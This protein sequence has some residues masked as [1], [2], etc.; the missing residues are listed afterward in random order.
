M[1]VHQERW[2]ERAACAGQAHSGYSPWD[3]M[4]DALPG[5]GY[6]PAGITAMART[7]CARCP[8]QL[9]C[10]AEAK[11]NGETGLWGGVMFVD[12]VPQKVGVAA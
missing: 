12:G 4:T 5:R 6:V 8:V 9:D 11:R 2:Y 7:F 3:W 10:F 1:V